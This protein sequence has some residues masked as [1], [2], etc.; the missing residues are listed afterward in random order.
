MGLFNKNSI[1][2]NLTPLIFKKENGTDFFLLDTNQSEK[3]W[4]QF[5]IRAKKENKVKLV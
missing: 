4:L 3:L 5:H 2:L 1:Q